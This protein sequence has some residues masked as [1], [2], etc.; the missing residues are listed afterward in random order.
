MDVTLSSYHCYCGLQVQEEIGL[1]VRCCTVDPLLLLP[2]GLGLRQRRAQRGYVS[3]V[4]ERCSG[5]SSALDGER[6]CEVWLQDVQEMSETVWESSSF[7]VAVGLRVRQVHRFMV[8]TEAA[9]DWWPCS[10]AAAS[11]RLLA[12]SH[13]RLCWCICM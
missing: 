5:G 11:H 12:D 1:T 7:F 8:G 9:L 4:L 2:R 10:L 13:E 6:V 3:W